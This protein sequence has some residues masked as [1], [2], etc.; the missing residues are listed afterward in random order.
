[1]DEEIIKRIVQEEIAKLA[2]LLQSGKT[3]RHIPFAVYMGEGRVLTKSY[4]DIL[5][6]VSSYDCTM[7]PHFILNGSYESEL[8]KYLLNNLQEDSVFV[9][10]GANFGYYTCIAGKKI[11][12]ASGGKVFAFEA[13]YRAYE[14]LEKNIILNWLDE[15]AVKTFETALSDEEKVMEFSSYKY[16]FGGSGF[17]THE[18]KDSMLNEVEILMI[19]TQKLDNCIPD[20]QPVDFMKID[21]EGAEFNV[22]KGA[23]RI[24]RRN[25]DIRIILEWDRKQLREQGTEIGDLVA[26]LKDEEFLAYTL[27]WEDGS[28][29]PVTYELLAETETHYCGILFDRKK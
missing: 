26:F 22:L 15:T 1:M 8:T 24:I 16:R 23:T 14:L 18:D 29:N 28:T 10:I 2:P 20:D 13:N 12:K 4:Y 6:L 9:D 3:D 7:T 25:R 21:V 5:Y 11:K 19:Q 17:R 27:N